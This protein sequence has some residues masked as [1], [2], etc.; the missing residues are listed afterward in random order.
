MV[1]RPSQGGQAQ[2]QRQR[3]LVGNAP[4]QVLSALAEQCR[5]DPEIDLLNVLGPADQPACWSSRPLPS[6][7]SSL[8]S[9]L[10]G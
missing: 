3:Y 6:A 7:R 9:M 1:Q 8:S 2:L 5:M 10:L 4:P